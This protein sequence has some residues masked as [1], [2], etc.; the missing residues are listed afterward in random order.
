LSII[1]F[2]I[3]NKL[4]GATFIFDIFLGADFLIDFRGQNG[5]AP[6]IS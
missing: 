2:F 3:F 6:H 4:L 1:L 5:S